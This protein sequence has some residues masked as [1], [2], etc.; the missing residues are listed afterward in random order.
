MKGCDDVQLPLRNILRTDEENRHVELGTLLL[1][2]VDDSGCGSTTRANPI[3]LLVRREKSRR[4]AE[5]SKTPRQA[6]VSQ[7]LCNKVLSKVVSFA[8]RG[9][10]QQRD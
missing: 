5:R 3:E 8:D 7:S 10:R 9:G 6:L 2:S 1:K 4:V